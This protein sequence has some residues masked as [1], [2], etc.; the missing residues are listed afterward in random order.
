[1]ERDDNANALLKRNAL[2]TDAEIEDPAQSKKEAERKAWA[3]RRE[4]RLREK[5]LYPPR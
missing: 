2:I 1:M 5:R 4:L 3:E